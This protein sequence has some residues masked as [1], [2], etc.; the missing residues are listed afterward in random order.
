MEQTTI[1]KMLALFEKLFKKRTHFRK[2]AKQKNINFPK[3]SEQKNEEDSL[4]LF[5]F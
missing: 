3:L 1:L 4:K 2:L 5:K